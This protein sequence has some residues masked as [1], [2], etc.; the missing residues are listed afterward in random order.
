MAFLLPEPG[1][2]KPLIEEGIN[3]PS[4]AVALSPRSFVHMQRNAFLS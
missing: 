2:P 4:P 3:A 1:N